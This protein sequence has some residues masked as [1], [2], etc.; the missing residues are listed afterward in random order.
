MTV[1]PILAVVVPVFCEEI[2]LEENLDCIRNTVIELG[3]SFEM[4]IVDDGSTDSTWEILL[5]LTKQWNELKALQLSRNFGKEA[6]ICAGL[7]TVNCDA[8]IVM[9]SDLQ[10]PPGL[11]PQMV[12]L[13]RD[14][15]YQIVEA[16]KTD[17][18]KEKLVNKLGAKLFYNLLNRLSGYDLTGES[19]YKL[20][21]WKVLDAWR[22]MQER[23][24][25]FRGMSAWLGYKK[26]KIPFCVPERKNG[27]SRW[28]FTGLIRLALIAV[29]S[30]STMPLHIVTSLGFILFVWSVLMGLQT[31]YVKGTGQA[32]SGFT[33]VILLNL[34]I[35]SGI[36]LS[37]GVIGE[38][39]ARI[40]EE[41]KH[42]PRYLVNQKVGFNEEQRL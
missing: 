21:D 19:D 28:S 10:H 4:V 14:E 18:G 42:R 5:R 16:V 22:L 6:A 39:I 23:H 35:G 12:K 30:F 33:T 29:T 7:A 8:V 24:V 1:K 15:G 20:L 9:D 25:F 27:N 31:L 40:Y 38:Y 37:L 3:Y 13:W 11:I 32:I 26:A 41:V 36:M 2:D 17:R 34:I